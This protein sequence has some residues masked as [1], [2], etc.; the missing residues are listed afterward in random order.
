MTIASSSLLDICITSTFER[1]IVSRVVPI[2]I[3]DHYMI[4]IVRKINAYSKQKWHKKTEFRNLKYFNA[5][6]FQTDLLT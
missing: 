4:V 3:S 6:N 2:A 5:N 1:L